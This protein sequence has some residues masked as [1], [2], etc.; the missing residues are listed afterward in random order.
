MPTRDTC[1]YTKLAYNSLRKYNSPEHEIIVLDDN[2]DDDT[3]SFF[4]S[5]TNDPNLIYKRYNTGKSVGHPE[6]YN[7]GVKLSRHPIITIFHSDMV[8]SQ[9]YIENMTFYLEKKKVI[10]ATRVEPLGVY[11]PD[12]AKILMPFGKYDHDFDEKTFIEFCNLES[13]KSKGKVTQGCFAPWMV[14]KEDY[15]EHEK[16]WPLEDS[17]LFQRFLL[18]GMKLEQPRDVLVYHFGSKAHKGWAKRG[19]GNDSDEFKVNQVLAQREYLRKWHAPIMNSS[20]SH[21]IVPK[22]FN[23]S[24]ELVGCSEQD[25]DILYHIEQF[26]SICYVDNDS[27]LSSYITQEQPNTRFNLNDRVKHIR[28]KSEHDIELKINMYQF[29]VNSQK[30]F[31]EIVNMTKNI[32]EVGEV[33]EYEF[34]CFT[35]KINN[36]IDRAMELILI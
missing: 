4:E 27:L 24:F 1:E 10:S 5:I 11:P 8:S 36:Y 17:D 30:Y 32:V 23:I 6:L 2:S 3:Q 13:T 18:N 35:L 25:I 19:I 12:N 22:V 16:Y 33:G 28:N 29:K 34:D 31:Q 7:I 15:L 26:C 20:F 9:N 21:P 14:Y